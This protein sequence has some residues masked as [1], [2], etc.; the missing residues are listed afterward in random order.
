VVVVVV[1]PPQAAR[2][3]PKVAAR[4][5]H[6]LRINHYLTHKNNELLQNLT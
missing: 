1:P 4:I 6:L 5:P 3:R 2:V